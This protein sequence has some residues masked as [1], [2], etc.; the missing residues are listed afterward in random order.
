VV[1]TSWPTEN[2]GAAADCSW[3][4]VPSQSQSESAQ[5]APSSSIHENTPSGMC[6][7]IKRTRTDKFELAAPTKSSPATTSATTRLAASRKLPARKIEA[8]PTKLEAVDDS[9][10][11]LGP[12]GA[13]PAPAPSSTSIE[14]APTP[15]R[16]ESNARV[17][18]QGPVPPPADEHEDTTLP[19]GRQKGPPPVQPQAGNL[20]RQTQPSVSVEQAAK[21]TFSIAVGDPHK[22][23]DLTSS[24]IVYQVHTKASLE[25]W[26]PFALADPA[27]DNVEG[28]QATRI[29]CLTPVS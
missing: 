7:W 14:Q 13:E 15:P 11:P 23:G 10:D 9:L 25:A 5:K 29:Y 24:H 17:S 21:P 4:D 26:S 12:L 20:P 1:R 6:K 22:V 8:Q 27:L 19:I 16:K 3:P 18:R 28:V 2:A